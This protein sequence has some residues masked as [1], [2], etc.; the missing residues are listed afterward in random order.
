[1]KKNYE[2]PN[3]IFKSVEK[4]ILTG[5]DLYASDIYLGEHGGSFRD[6]NLFGDIN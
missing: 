3:V 2:H 5:S 4:D 6:E 1:M